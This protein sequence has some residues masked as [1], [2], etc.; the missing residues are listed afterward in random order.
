MEV[1]LLST[2]P[3]KLSCKSN[4]DYSKHFNWSY[5]LKRDVYNCY[6]RAR[7][8]PAVGYMKR[9][10]SFWDE[11]YPELSFLS[12]KNLRDQASRIDKNKVVMETEYENINTPEIT[13]NYLLNNGNNNADNCLD[14]IAVNDVSTDNNVVVDNPVLSEEQLKIVDL[15]DPFFK[16]NYEIIKVKNF[17]DRVHTT[18]VN[19]AISNGVLLAINTIANR[20]LLNIS[21]LKFWEVNV[22]LY[23]AAVL[24][25]QYTANLKQIE[26]KPIRKNSAPG[27]IKQLEHSIKFIQKEIAQLIIMIECKKTKTYSKHQLKLKQL[28][29]KCHGDFRLQTLQFKLSILYQNLKAKSTKLEYNKRRIERKS[30]NN[31]FRKNPKAV[32]RSMKGNNTNATEILTTEGIKSFYKNIW[33]KESNFHKEANGLKIW[34]RIIVRM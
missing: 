3:Q 29:M 30:I 25:K 33:G 31:K 12:D 17:D 5:K 15:R 32:Y 6:L 24:A 14:N 13:E 20:H 10:K 4:R 1:S 2:M 19:K 18:D 9:F 26:H 8:N 11:I 34:R 22:T 7:E 28:F 23:A 21:D 27:W 16:S